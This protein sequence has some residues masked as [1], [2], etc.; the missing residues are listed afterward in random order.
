MSE[1]APDVESQMKD[2]NSLYHTVKNIIKIRKENPDLC[3]NGDFEILFAEKN[4]YPFIFRRGSF[5]IAVNPSA[6]DAFAPFG[7]EMKEKVYSIGET[8]VSNGT[9]KLKGQ[10]Y[11]LMKI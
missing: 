3:G 2:E 8:V 7:Y 6:N 4:T 10:S 5:V 1:N 9:I 11:C